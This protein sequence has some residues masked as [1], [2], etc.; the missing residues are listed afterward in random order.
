MHINWYIG[1]VN[2]QEHIDI[3]GVNLHFVDKS[4]IICYILNIETKAGV[5]HVKEKNN[6]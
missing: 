3:G 4:H 5:L 2:L 6:G 1:G